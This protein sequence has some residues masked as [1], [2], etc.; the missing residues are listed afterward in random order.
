MHIL[1]LSSCPTGTV[2]QTFSGVTLEA[3]DAQLMLN[4]AAL[5]QTIADTMDDVL[6]LNV[7]GLKAS[8]PDSHNHYRTG[9]VDGETDREGEQQSGFISHFIYF[10]FGTRGDLSGTSISSTTSSRRRSRYSTSSGTRSG[11][12]NGGVFPDQQQILL[13]LTTPLDDDS[14]D[15]IDLRHYRKKHDD[16]KEKEKK[17]PTLRIEYSVRVHDARASYQQMSTDLHFAVS[18]GEF[19]SFM[20]TVATDYGAA[21]LMNLTAL[22]VSTAVVHDAS[23]AGRSEGNEAEGELST[24]EIVVLVVVAL[25][26]LVVL[27]LLVICM[28]DRYVQ[29]ADQLRDMQSKSLIS[30]VDMDDASSDEEISLTSS[31]STRGSRHGSRHGSG[32]RISNSSRHGGSRRGAYSATTIYFDQDPLG[33]SSR[34]NGDSSHGDTG[35]QSILSS[36]RTR[37][38][39]W[40]WRIS[41]SAAPPASADSDGGNDLERGRGQGTGTGRDGEQ[42]QRLVSEEGEAISIQL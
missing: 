1:S 11:T 13:N 41:S 19:D 24:R 31:G 5:Q 10:I 37:R 3:F 35:S 20:R 28:R 39:K 2:W 6:P 34:G 32:G 4:E 26:A 9:E 17:T 21:A 14:S 40:Q 30:L 7:V 25:V 36:F 33:G 38:R 22:S 15:A 12:G 16:A 8:S 18:S 27:V 23:T 42:G 29:I